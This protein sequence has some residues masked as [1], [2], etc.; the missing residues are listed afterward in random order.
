MQKKFLPLLILALQG[1][2]LL[3]APAVPQMS[4]S[5]KG[6]DYGL[7][8]N[9]PEN[10]V[11]NNRV[12]LKI[13]GKPI[14]VIDVVKKMDLFFY[15]QYPELASSIPA[16]YQFYASGWRT[17]LSSLIDDQL[18]LADAEERKI[19]VTDGEVRE[20]L[21][22]LFGPEV[23]INLDKI[24]M[25]LDEAFELLKTE[26]L[27]QK[28]TNIMVRSRALTD[29]HPKS[30]RER[31]QELIQ[32]N[33]PQEFMVYQILSV[34]GEE[35]ERVAKKAHALLTEQNVPFKEIVAAL[36]EPKAEVSYSEEYEQ[37]EKDLSLAYRAVLKTLSAGMA[38]AP[39]SKKDV[40]RIFCLKEM[41]K[42]EGLTFGNKSD[43]LKQELL[44]QAFNDRNTAYR[45]KLR[46]DYGLTDRYLNSLIPEDLQPF[47]MN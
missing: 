6:M 17:I 35:H 1:S 16:R 22:K 29:V 39:V 43:E 18:I 36:D 40:S 19:T 15:R 4:T 30:V 27:V 10:L 31:Y 9:M 3:A 26:L 44:S 25:T 28:M 5:L 45:Q 13:L 23:V 41:R 20:E 2:A 11:I 14:S 38:S 8:Q 32:A 46:K 47:S 24:D 42:E 37:K 12:L 33:P 34:R 7:G 21:E